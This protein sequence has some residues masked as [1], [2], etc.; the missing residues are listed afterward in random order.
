MPYL[1]PSQEVVSCKKGPQAD[2]DE[3]DDSDDDDTLGEEMLL[4][5]AM[6]V[7]SLV[8]HST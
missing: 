1:G 4:R 8:I 3:D 6:I 5:Q 2:A 7:R